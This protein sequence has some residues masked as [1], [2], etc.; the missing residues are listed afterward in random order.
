MSDTPIRNLPVRNPRTGQFDYQIAAPEA[1]ELGPLA[2]RLRTAQTAW[3]ALGIAQRSAVLKGWSGRLLGEPSTL[4]DAL[5]ADS[6]RLR[7]SANE[8]N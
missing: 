6:G 5:A 2:A 1:A 7:L 8:V 4:L 3:A